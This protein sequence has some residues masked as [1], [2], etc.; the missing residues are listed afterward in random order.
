[1]GAPAV[2]GPLMGAPDV[3]RDPEGVP[4]CKGASDVRSTLIRHL[5]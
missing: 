5:M 1:M 2:R 3:R 4:S